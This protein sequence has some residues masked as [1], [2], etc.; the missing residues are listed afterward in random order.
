MCFFSDRTIHKKV[1]CVWAVWPQT[2]DKSEKMFVETKKFTKKQ[3][4]NLLDIPCVVSV[5]KKS[6][7]IIL[8][9]DLPKTK[10]ALHPYYIL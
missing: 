4:V 9:E 3:T 1:I 6:N 8:G 5:S 7:S 10:N 2:C